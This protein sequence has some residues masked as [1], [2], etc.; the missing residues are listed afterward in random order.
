MVVRNIDQFPDPERVIVQGTCAGLHATRGEVIVDTDT[1]NVRYG[2]C[3]PK[4]KMVASE[5]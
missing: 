3:C 4:Y 5:L 2:G 1:S